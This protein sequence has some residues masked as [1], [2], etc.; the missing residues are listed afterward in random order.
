MDL[1]IT[2]KQLKQIE[3]H[4]NEMFYN[5]DQKQLIQ[6]RDFEFQNSI[7]GQ[8]IFFRNG[9]N[10]FFTTLKLNINRVHGDNS[11]RIIC[12]ASNHDVCIIDYTLDRFEFWKQ[13][14][15]YTMDEENLDKLLS[16]LQHV[17]EYLQEPYQNIYNPAVK[18]MFMSDEI[19][20]VKV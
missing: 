9:V 12:D 18:Q 11:F 8:K 20:Q 2:K 5:D 1:L 4:L 16:V 13:Y 15:T 14:R 17:C 6:K 10:D 3:K 19:K 7:K